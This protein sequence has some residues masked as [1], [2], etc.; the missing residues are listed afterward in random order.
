M[1]CTTRSRSRRCQ[2]CPWRLLWPIQPT[3]RSIF[4]STC[5][6][7]GLRDERLLTTHSCTGTR[8]CLVVWIYSCSVQLIPSSPCQHRMICF[9]QLTWTRDRVCS[10]ARFLNPFR[11]AQVLFLRAI[12]CASLGTT[13]PQACI[14]T[15]SSGS[16][17]RCR[18]WVSTARHRQQFRS[19]SLTVTTNRRVLVIVLLSSVARGFATDIFIGCMDYENLEYF[20]KITVPRLFGCVV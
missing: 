12:A 16:R 8:I 10:W 6:C 18:G 17:P 15:S 9:H 19:T 2:R 20:F 14:C 1:L 7:C 5:L 13:A 11:S 4:S 3:L